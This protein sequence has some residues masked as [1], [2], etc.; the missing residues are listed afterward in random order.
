MLDRFGAIAIA[1]TL[2]LCV[3][4]TFL[5]LLHM[6]WYSGERMPMRFAFPALIVVALAGRVSGRSPFVIGAAAASAIAI[7]CGALGP[8]LVALWFAVSCSLLGNWVVTKLAAD[9]DSRTLDLLVG[10]ALYGTTVGLLAHL[11]VNY[12]GAYAAALAL[13][14][15]LRRQTLRQW[16]N[17][18]RQHLSASSQPDGSE[19][20]WVEFGIVVV[21]LVHFAVAM[22]P[23]VGHDALAM[24]LFIPAHLSQRHEWGF[25]AGTYVWAVMPMMGDWIFSIAYMLGGETAARLVNVG[26]I[27]VLAVL[28]RDMVIWAGGEALGARWAMLL[29]LSTPLTFTESSSLYIESMWACFVVAGSLAI[30]KAIDPDREASAQFR[31]GGLLLGSALAAKAVTV[32]VLPALL[33]VLLFRWR[34]WLRA[35]CVPHIAMGVSLLLVIGAIPY[36]TAFFFTGNPVF[37]FFNDVFHSPFYPSERF[38]DARFGSGIAWDVLYDVTFRSTIYLEGAPG[39]AGF[40]WLVLFVPAILTLAFGRRHKGT[41]LLIVGG[42]SVV[43]AFQFT[44]YLRYIFPSFVWVSAGIGVA[45]SALASAS[46]NARR[47]V[48]IVCLGVVG[49]NVTYFRSGTSYGDLSLRALTSQAGREAYI[50]SHLPIQAA[51]E[52]INRLNVGR[53]PVAV[54]SV[55]LTAPLSADALYP[56]WYNFRFQELVAGATSSGAIAALL[57]A[58]GVDYVIVDEAWGTADQ[59]AKIAATSDKIASFGGISVRSLKSETRFQTELLQS[60][61]FSRIDA[62]SL[63]PGTQ[64][65]ADGGVAAGVSSP[66]SQTV[67]VIAG[68]RYLLSVTAACA[69]EPAQGRLQVNWLDS[70][71][72]FIEATASVFACAQSDTL[73]SME[74]VAPLDAAYATVYAVGHTETPIRFRMVSFKQ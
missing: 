13:P 46:V 37:P 51:V 11:P 65:L 72:N 59:R 71:S 22:M 1:A 35:T 47:L 53:T 15:V 40:Q 32:T 68:H 33:L 14:L 49:L 26:F 63:S 6:P 30:F 52:L 17:A 58:E 36:V 8:L 42:L 9:T 43:V 24:H 2:L 18:A 10:A 31:L 28:I 62:W 55:P 56:N 3:A 27:F 29:F 48:S 7:V 20:R 66:T 70:K 4:L 67:V 64:L 41:L 44:A 23:E 38:S 21:A 61:D 73:H 5:G 45:V 12:P 34:A 60:P 69:D 19:V 54:F 39:A 16:V 74:V 50:R 25:D 57:S